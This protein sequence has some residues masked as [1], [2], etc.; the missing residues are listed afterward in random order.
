[1]SFGIRGSRCEVFV[2]SGMLFV[3]RRIPLISFLHGISVH[4]IGL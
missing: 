1:M 3:L 4:E 2:R